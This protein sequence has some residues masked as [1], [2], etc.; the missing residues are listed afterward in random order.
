MLTAF[1]V[2]SL[3][4]KCVFYRP[5]H[6]ANGGHLKLN[7]EGLLECKD[8]INQGT[9]A[10]RVDDK[11][12]PFVELSCLFPEFWLLKCQKWRFFIFPADDSKK[13]VKL[14]AQ[15]VSVTKWSSPVNMITRWMTTFFNLLSELYLLLHFILAFQDLLNSYLWGPPLHY[16]PVCKLQ[17]FTCQSWR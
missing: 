13:I 5:K 4:N 6:S 2:S 10:Q 7:F 8:K 15:H 3:A 12:G 9:S 16:I 17:F 14:W 1:K 11:M